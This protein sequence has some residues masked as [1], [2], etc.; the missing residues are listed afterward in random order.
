M[1]FG[2]G[3]SGYLTCTRLRDRRT[4][5]PTECV[6]SREGSGRWALVLLCVLAVKLGAEE[7]GLWGGIPGAGG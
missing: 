2:S 3:L 7:R 5:R 4:R 1:L 6:G